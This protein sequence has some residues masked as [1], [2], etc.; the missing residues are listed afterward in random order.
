MAPIENYVE[1]FPDKIQ[2]DYYN[3]DQAIQ[4]RQID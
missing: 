3:Y 1:K 2:K 4:R